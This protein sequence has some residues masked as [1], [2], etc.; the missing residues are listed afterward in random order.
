MSG[1]VHAAQTGESERLDLLE[2]QCSTVD[3]TDLFRRS[4]QPSR[5]PF[6]PRPNQCETMAIQE[7]RKSRMSSN[8]NLCALGL[9]TV[10]EAASFLRIS[11]SKLYL[12]MKNGELPFVRLGG[13]RRV[14]KLAVVQ[15]AE[16]NVE[17]AGNL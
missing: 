15:I 11:R 13:C 3:G 8:E 17:H 12:L 10:P 2:Q 16:R 6:F 5:S 7:C 1:A 9:L 4:M 14:P